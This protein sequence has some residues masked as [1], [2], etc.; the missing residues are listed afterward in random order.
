MIYLL[1]TNFK[2]VARCMKDL[3]IGNLKDSFFSCLSWHFFCLGN[4]PMVSSFNAARNVRNDM[5]FIG[6]TLGYFEQ[7]F[8]IAAIVTIPL[9]AAALA[10]VLAMKKLWT[11]LATKWNNLM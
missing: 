2:E 9:V 7:A 5:G 4:G 1:E 8:A 11:F 3:S 6:E 10:T